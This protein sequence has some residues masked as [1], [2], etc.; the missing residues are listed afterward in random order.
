METQLISHPNRFLRWYGLTLTN[1]A[2]WLLRISHKYAD[3]VV[4]LEEDG[5]TEWRTTKYFD[6]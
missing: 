3:R 2:A 4:V 6:C 5:V 1:L